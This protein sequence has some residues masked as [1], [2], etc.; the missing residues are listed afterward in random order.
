MTA[1]APVLLSERT[2]EVLILVLNRPRA[3]NALDSSL[4]E[5]LVAQ[6]EAADADADV[7]ALVLGAVGERS[8]SAGADL[9]EFGRLERS[10]ASRRRRALLLRTLI[11]VM[12]FG[13]PLVA[14]VEGK[15]LGAG[16][17]LAL[18]ADE[19]VAGDEAQFGMPEILLG[20]PS[21]MGADVI[22][23]R[24]GS[25]LARRLVQGGQPIGAREAHRQGLIDE[26]TEA[27][28]LYRTSLE[29]ARALARLAGSA[30]AGNKRWMNRTLRASLAA[31]AAESE[32]LQAAARSRD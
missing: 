20:M 9:K 31:A 7:R 27:P 10:E 13:K 28:A 23:A 2:G 25:R 32:R 26:V 15:A 8:F 11:A 14:R 24:A 4:H 1:D 12:D 16:C 21:P 6:L 17:M 18:L 5:A 30:Y 29:R 3:A 19:I 22:A